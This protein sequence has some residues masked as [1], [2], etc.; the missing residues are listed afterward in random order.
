M[1]MATAQSSTNATRAKSG[2]GSTDM[3]IKSDFGQITTGHNLNIN[4]NK[5]EKNKE[6]N[7]EKGRVAKGTV[8][9]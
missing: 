3:K 1:T 8:R 5:D 6:K 7:K 2:S 4:M 9:I